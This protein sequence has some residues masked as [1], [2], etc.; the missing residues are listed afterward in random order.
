[1]TVN[2]KN[3]NWNLEGIRSEAGQSPLGKRTKCPKK[4][5]KKRKKKEKGGKKGRKRRKKKEINEKMTEKT[6]MAARIEEP[7][8]QTKN[9]FIC[10][11]W[12]TC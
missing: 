3:Q 1:M 2:E 5:E 11:I 10:G 12:K 9:P 6:P 4:K 7:G 8:P